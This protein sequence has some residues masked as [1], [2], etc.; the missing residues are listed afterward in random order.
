VTEPPESKRPDDDRGLSN[1]AKGYRSGAP[2]IAASTQLVAAVV[3]FS[4]L[5][6]WIDGK[7]GNEKPWFLLAGA[8]IGMTGGFISF[9]RTVLGKR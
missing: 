4:L 6:W 9:F 2:Y 3:L 1:L 5:G 7:V 8:L